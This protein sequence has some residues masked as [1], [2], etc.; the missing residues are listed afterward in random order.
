MPLWLME[1]G[2]PR[3]PAE[4]ATRSDVVESANVAALAGRL[5]GVEGWDVLD[6]KDAAHALLTMA[7]SPSPPTALLV[8]ATHRRTGRSAN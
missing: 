3:V 2:E 6:D 7:A 5:D 4:W 1:V 8:M